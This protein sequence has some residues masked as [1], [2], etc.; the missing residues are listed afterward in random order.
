MSALINFVAPPLRLK[1]TI[2]KGKTA[3]NVG[4]WII[5]IGKERKKQGGPTYSTLQ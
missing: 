5:L 2:Q 4:T 1:R 3:V